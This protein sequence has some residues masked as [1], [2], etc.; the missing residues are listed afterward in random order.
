MFDLGPVTYYRP[1][2]S[3]DDR[4]A[5][6]YQGMADSGAVRGAARMLAEGLL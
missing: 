5:Y 6:L 4:L 1:R 3:E 2:Y